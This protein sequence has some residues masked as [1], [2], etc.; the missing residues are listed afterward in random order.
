MQTKY[1]MYVTWMLIA[2]LLLDCFLR[3]V[4]EYQCCEGLVRPLRMMIQSNRLITD[5]S[6]NKYYRS[7]VNQCGPHQRFL[8]WD[9]M[10]KSD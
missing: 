6:I 8:W 2:G 4:Q 1:Y 5:Q 7:A 9:M 3:V 10:M